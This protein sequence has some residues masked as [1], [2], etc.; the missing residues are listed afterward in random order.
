M[1]GGGLRCDELEALAPELALGTL[2]GSERADAVAHLASCARC[3]RRVAGLARVVDAM[4][5]LAPEDDASDELAAGVLARTVGDP[6]RDR[7][8]VVARRWRRPLLAGVAGAVAIVAAIMIAML[9]GDDGGRPD[10]VR[11]AVAV[12]DGGASVCRAVINEIDPAWLF[13]SL[14][15]E[16]GEGSEYVVELVLEG[17]ASVRVGRLEVRDGH[18]VLAVTLDLDAERPR[19][20]RLIGVG[21]EPGYVATFI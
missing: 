14:D 6:S 16:G 3:Q 17:G 15:E 11:A 21:D 20:V 5:L 10:R 4:V 2:T 1:S 18:G 7:R 12:E 9:V 8:A 19:A 13:V